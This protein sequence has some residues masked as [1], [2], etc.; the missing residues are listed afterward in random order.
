MIPA[1]YYVS[2]EQYAREVTALANSVWTPVC[3]ANE[4][5]GDGDYVVRGKVI[6]QNVGGELKAFLN[7]CPHRLNRLVSKPCGT[8]PLVCGYHGWEFGPDGLPCRVPKRPSF[9]G[10]NLAEHGLAVYEA[11]RCGN[12]VF[13]CRTK[14]IELEAW[15]GN[16]WGTI[17][18]MTDACG[19]KLD[20]NRIWMRCNWKIAVENTLEA[21]HVG[22]VHPETFHRLG[23]NGGEFSFAGP[24]S[25]WSTP[26]SAK[27]T[28]WLESMEDVFASRPY[29]PA[30][31]VHQLVF[32]HCTIASAAGM[33]VSVQ[34][35]APAGV[36]E[37]EFTSL[38]YATKVGDL[39]PAQAERREVFNKSVVDFNRAVFAEDAA[40]CE[41]VHAGA[42]DAAGSGV[43]A[44]LSEDEERV[45]HHISALLMA[46]DGL[47]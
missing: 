16:A 27:T 21:Y 45:G 5:A 23:A 6:V 30:G 8:G 26:L 1:A 39:S 31:Y 4:I 22:H 37:T 19:E 47:S 42:C 33:S 25:S 10:V 15:L 24:H 14:A 43:E 41:S 28:A 46:C 7:V 13:V 32:P 9:D 18:A 34:F 35:F 17:A 11:A 12:L 38:V 2:E 40:V 36:G 29:K 20:T 3:M 44:I